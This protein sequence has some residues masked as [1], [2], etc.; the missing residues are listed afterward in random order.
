MNKVDVLPEL[1][2]IIG[3][4]LFAAKN[5]LD[6]HS[7]KKV[8]QQTAEEAGGRAEEYAKA[9]ES[10]IEE[11]LE[12][13]AAQINGA[14]MGFRIT[15][16]AGGYQLE[17]DPSCGHW[18]RIFLDK[19]KPN[20]LSKPALETLAVIAYRQPCTRADIEEIRGVAVSHMVKNLLEMQL[21]KIVGRSD[22]PGRPWL[23]GTTH[24][25]LEH[26]GLR[27]LDDL[28]NMKELKFYKPEK[29]DKKPDPQA[30]LNLAEEQEA[31]VQ[32]ES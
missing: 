25:F 13:Y 23:F 18:L 6:A 31:S 15:H 19:S 7:I 8:L 2:E 24:L 29:Q 10:M 21:V 12:N 17:N 5:S 11:V 27:S 20:R 30:E 3:S 1:K 16:V 22:L 9:S 28:P 26:F 32:D 4:M 14:A